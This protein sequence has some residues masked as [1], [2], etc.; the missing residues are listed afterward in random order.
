MHT[1]LIAQFVDM[2]AHGVTDFSMKMAPFFVSIIT[3][4]MERYIMSDKTKLEFKGWK[5]DFSND[6]RW[7]YR[8]YRDDSTDPS[9][10]GFGDSIEDC[11]ESIID[12]FYWPQEGW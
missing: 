8:Y 2:K 10:T 3:S 5:I 4:I 1:K 6:P 11:I 9:L 12:S 7:A